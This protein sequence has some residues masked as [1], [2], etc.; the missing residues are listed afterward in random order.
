MSSVDA[1]RQLNR[2]A[3]GALGMDCDTN[4]GNGTV[5]SSC[6]QPGR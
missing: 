5:V 6:V 1:S 4:S 3:D 2:G